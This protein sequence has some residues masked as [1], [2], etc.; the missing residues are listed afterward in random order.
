MMHMRDWISFFTGALVAVT[1]ILPLLNMAGIGPSW[2]AL[3]FMPI[4]ILLY[5][6]AGAG[7]YLLINSFI[8]ITNSNVVG[9]ISLLIA[10]VI[11]A[12]GVFKVLGGFGIGPEFFTLSFIP[13][14]VYKVFLAVEGLFLMIACFA[15]EL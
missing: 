12:I 10:L 6:V 4:S 13:D 2:F 5:M 1:G 9:W 3:D 14:I 15:M 7:M 11:G 8:E